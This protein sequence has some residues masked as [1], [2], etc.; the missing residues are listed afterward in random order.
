[1]RKINP[2][3]SNEESFKYS[4][5]LSLHYYDISCHPERLSKLEPYVNRYIFSDTNPEEFGKNN[6]NISLTVYN[7]NDE[8]TYTP[9]NNSTN[10]ARIAKINDNRYAAIKPPIPDT[11]KLEKILSS[12]THT[13]L[14]KLLNKI[15]LNKID[16]IESNVWIYF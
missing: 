13:E 8:I 5:L 2:K 9:N 3:S 10:K 12:C 14:S 4:I 7:N 11:I 6:P 1:M 15:I 16:D